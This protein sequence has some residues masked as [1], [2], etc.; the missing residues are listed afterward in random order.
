M[1]PPERLA[2]YPREYEMS[3]F[4]RFLPLLLCWTFVACSG[5]DSP[6]AN[7]CQ[8]EP[9]SPDTI[10]TRWN[11]QDKEK[12]LARITTVGWTC[13]KL[14]E[15]PNLNPAWQDSPQLSR[16]GKSFYLLHASWDLVSWMEAG[17]D[18]KKIDCFRQGP[19]L[20]GNTNGKFYRFD[21]DQSTGTISN[22]VRFPFSDPS[23]QVIE[24]CGF[25]AG[26]DWYYTSFD[27]RTGAF[28]TFRN[29]VRQQ[30]VVGDEFFDD[31]IFH[32]GTLYFWSKELSPTRT[33][34]IFTARETAPNQWSIPEPMPAPINLDASNERQP[35]WAA[36]GNFYF[37]SDRAGNGLELYKATR[38][39]GSW[40]TSKIIGITD[41][42]P[43]G[44]LAVAAI[45]EI[46][47]ADSMGFATFAVVFTD[48]ASE[49]YDADILY[50]KPGICP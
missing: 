15:G 48:L 42:I 10:K 37:S 43:P 5:S 30:I 26:S 36:D 11:R 45:G 9:D 47:F 2:G 21:L 4:Q 31:S 3:L 12:A 29:G 24:C 40:S 28:G 32:D 16:D 23:E 41:E 34:T 27:L 22:P 19:A 33:E 13:P 35:M 46:S 7:D 20:D 50:V 8:R 18:I 25:P 38:A 44:P 49:T 1:A 39:G 17:S 6:A 14:M